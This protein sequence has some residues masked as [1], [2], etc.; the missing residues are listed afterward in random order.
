[1]TKENVIKAVKE[2]YLPL[3]L[4][5]VFW[6]SGGSSLA[7]I[8]M[9]HTGVRWFAPINWTTRDESKPLVASTA[10][11]KVSYVVRLDDKLDDLESSEVEV[12]YLT[13][14]LTSVLNDPYLVLE[15][16]LRQRIEKAV[17]Q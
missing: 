15:P 14:L 2:R 12:E 16:N 9:T 7:S 13:E 5:R 8:G 3:G 6:V 11:D 1:M 17:G 4:Y 10:W